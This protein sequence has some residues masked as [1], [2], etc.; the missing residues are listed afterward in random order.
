MHLLI[1]WKAW[2]SSASLT[3]WSPC[4]DVWSAL[5][6]VISMQNIEG[7]N[8]NHG[9]I[10]SLVLWQ[11]RRGSPLR[12]QRSH[13]QIYAWGDR[14]EY[15]VLDAQSRAI[16]FPRAEISTIKHTFY[17][18]PRCSMNNSTN[19]FTHTWIRI[20]NAIFRISMSRRLSD[21]LTFDLTSR[22]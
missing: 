3:P 8:R 11:F 16:E 1:R 10:Y 19:A 14:V 12:Q 17:F 20:S 22:I 15:E 5:A 2:L 18:R 4:K 7:G 9:D 21:F 6:L 13:V